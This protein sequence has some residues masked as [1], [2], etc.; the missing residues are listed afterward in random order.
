VDIADKEDR[1]LSVSICTKVS[2]TDILHGSPLS[3][4][5]KP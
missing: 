1:I 5:E 3:V 4:K 2:T